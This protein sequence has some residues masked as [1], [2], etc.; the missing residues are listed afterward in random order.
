M[1]PDDD[2]ARFEDDET[3]WD[4]AAP[5]GITRDTSTLIRHS[6][7]EFGSSIATQWRR[8]NILIA[9]DAAHVMPPFLGQGMCS[10]IRDAINLVW[11]LALV[12]DG[13]ASTDLLDTYMAERHDHV[14]KL[15]H[16]SIEI[17]A[18]VSI[19][20]PTAAA[21]RDEALRS[22]G[23]PPPPDP[24]VLPAGV[25]HAEPDGSLRRGVGALTLQAR[26]DI[27]GRRGKLDDLVPNP[28]RI[29]TRRR[30]DLEILGDHHKRLLEDLD[31]VIIPI[32]PAHADGFAFDVDFAYEAWFTELDAGVVIVRPDFYAFAVLDDVNALPDALD[33][34]ILKLRLL[35]PLTRNGAVAAL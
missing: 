13:S 30:V 7:Y 6:V 23:A 4:L 20:D 34:L 33:D 18:L 22:S 3:C 12:L 2:L 32:S 28:W 24:A 17:G 1:L 10:G 25:L 8:G 11:K 29:L 27:G 5:F 16:T 15:I 31:A 19:T 14:S 26:L 35:Y 21:R 9:G